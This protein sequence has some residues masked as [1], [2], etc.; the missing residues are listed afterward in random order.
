MGVIVGEKEAIMETV[1]AINKLSDEKRKIVMTST[2]TDTDD[3][4]ER[5][6]KSAENRPN[7]DL[8]TAFLV[9]NNLAPDYIHSMGSSSSSCDSSSSSCGGD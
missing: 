2:P 8:G 3:Y 1:K 6:R 7:D 9:A 5:R 4:Y